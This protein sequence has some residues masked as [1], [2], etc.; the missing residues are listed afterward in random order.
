MTTT[1]TTNEKRDPN[2]IYFY[3]GPLCNFTPSAIMLYGKSYPT[4]EHWYQANKAMDE[5]THDYV[6]S[7]ANARG[8]KAR[9]RSIHRRPD[10]EQLTEKG[11]QLKYEVML[12]GL[13]AKFALPQF[14]VI[15]LETGDLPIH[16]DSPDDFEWGWRNNGNDLMGRA[17]MQVRAEL[18]QGTAP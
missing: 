14:K 4:V 9:G 3:G 5:A 13:R 15:L 10:W 2:A 16:E 6:R 12:T 18:R 8:A 1:V 17:L 11:T 7:A